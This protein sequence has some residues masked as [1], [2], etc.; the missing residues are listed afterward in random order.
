MAAIYQVGKRPTQ[1]RKPS[2]V[3]QMKDPRGAKVK[4]PLEKIFESEAKDPDEIVTPIQGKDPGSV[5]E[6]RYSKGLDYFGIRYYYQYYVLGATFD[7]AG[8]QILDFLAD[9]NPLPTPVYIQGLYWHYGGSLDEETRYKIEALM[10]E[11]GGVFAE[12]VIVMAPE[13]T[14]ISAAIELIRGEPRLMIGGSHG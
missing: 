12:P 6:W 1:A 2:G 4:V 8:S 3:Y 14:S 11:Y 10:S 13:V 9:T 7:A 5:E